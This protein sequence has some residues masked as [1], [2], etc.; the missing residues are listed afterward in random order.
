MVAAEG[1]L[2]ATAP[3]LRQ[4]L[5]D[6]P[7]LGV[8]ISAARALGAVGGA[9][10]VAPLA[11]LT[12]PAQPTE[13]RRAAVLAL[14]ELGHLAAVPVLTGLLSDPDIR[15]AQHSGDALVQLGPSGVRALLEAAGGPGTPA[16]REYTAARVAAG[17]LA[18]ARLRKGPLT[19][20]EPAN[21]R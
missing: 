15:L 13:L 12:V 10:D 3:R 4:L 16:N 19:S 20:G 9:E 6:E 18:V 11:A 21:A 14:G 5:A 8:R 1:A 17:S 2:S 7:Q